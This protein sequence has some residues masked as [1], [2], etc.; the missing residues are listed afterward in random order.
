MMTQILDKLKVSPTT[1]S[2]ACMPAPPS[3]P[4]EPWELGSTACTSHALIYGYHAVPFIIQA[5]VVTVTPVFTFQELQT[6]L[7]IQS[8][9]CYTGPLTH[10]VGLVNYRAETGAE[11]GDNH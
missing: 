3:R 11:A 9:T 10:K 4:G 8:T 6:T 7:H 5:L 2:A 1:T